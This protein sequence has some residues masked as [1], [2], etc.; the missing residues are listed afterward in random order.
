MITKIR[1]QVCQYEIWQNYHVGC[2]Q[3]LIKDLI[4]TIFYKI[5]KYVEWAQILV[6]RSTKTTLRKEINVLL[7][8]FYCWLP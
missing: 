6:F 3:S 8:N 4:M 1:T 7:K 2:Q 5:K